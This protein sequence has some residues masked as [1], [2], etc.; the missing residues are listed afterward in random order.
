MKNKIAFITLG[1]MTLSLAGCGPSMPVYADADK[2]LAGNQTYQE[3]ITSLDIDWISGSVTLVE[4]PTIEGVKIEE[5]TDFT[6]PEELVHS[7][8]NDGDLKIKYFASGHMASWKARPY[9][10]ELTVTYKPGLTKIAI[11]L[12]SGLLNADTMTASDVDIDLTSGSAKVGAI[13]AETVDADLTSGTVDITSLTAK[14]FDSDMTSGT[15]NIGFTSIETASFDLTSGKINMTLPLL[16]GKVTV[17]K[18]SGT[19]KTERECKISNNTY[20]FGSGEADIKVS[21]TSGTVTIK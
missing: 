4:D 3:N 13:V 7:Y 6:E 16:G 5:V 11:D 14:S 12:T 8:M 10:K 21:M 9:K 15:V 1:L 18:T 2:Y 20:T 19:V 17:S